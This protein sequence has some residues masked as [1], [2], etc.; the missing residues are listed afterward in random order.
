MIKAPTNA[1]D[2][3]LHPLLIGKV[4][5]SEGGKEEIGERVAIADKVKIVKELKK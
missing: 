1:Y 3:G 4:V 2:G 5:R